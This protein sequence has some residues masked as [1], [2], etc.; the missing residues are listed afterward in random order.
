MS[1]KS[2]EFANE[3]LRMKNLLWAAL[4]LA[5][6]SITSCATTHESSSVLYQ[7]FSQYE[8]R[9][10][11]NNIIEVAGKFFS[12]ALLGE[13]YR[14][15]PDAAS[16]LLFKNY[17]VTIVDHHEK[18]DGQEGCLALNGYGEEKSPLIFSLKYVSSNGH[19]LIDK[20][21][22]AFVE[23]TADFVGSAKCPS[24]TPNSGFSSA[25]DGR[26]MYI[27]RDL[28]G[29]VRLMDRTGVYPDV[30]AV[31]KSKKY[32]ADNDIPR[33]AAKVDNTHVKSFPGGTAV[34]AIEVQGVVLNERK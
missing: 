13:N 21:H 14:T 4:V 2:N 16:Q 22:V 26:A 28:F 32:N 18:I 17:M 7:E 24:E 27:F 31:I 25:Q 30:A 3:A 6:L 5:A 12:P 11:E 34:L 23:D 29:N 8:K 20:I 19:W 1:L 33:F 10:N 15:D 9:A